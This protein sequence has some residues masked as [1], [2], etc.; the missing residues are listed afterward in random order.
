MEPISTEAVR[1]AITQTAELGGWYLRYPGMDS[2]GLVLPAILIVLVGGLVMFGAERSQTAKA[3]CARAVAAA[4]GSIG[5]LT[6]WTAYVRPVDEALVAP[7]KVVMQADAYLWNKPAP[8]GTPSVAQLLDAR[9]R[10]NAALRDA[11]HTLKKLCL[12]GGQ[13]CPEGK[14]SLAAAQLVLAL[15]R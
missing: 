6:L 9:H 2:G 1:A 8:E 4:M 11:D 14:Q 7:A 12:A 10:V 5:M 13:L 15:T 3:W